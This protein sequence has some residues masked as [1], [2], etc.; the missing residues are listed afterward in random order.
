MGSP[1]LPSRGALLRPHG[2]PSG[3]PAPARRS[4]A[5]R[6]AESIPSPSRSNFTRPASS[7]SSLSHCSTLR[8]GT[9]PQLM[10]QTLETG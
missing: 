4:K 5:R 8:P 6:R 1:R 7:Q 2:S 9:D 10:G 3:A